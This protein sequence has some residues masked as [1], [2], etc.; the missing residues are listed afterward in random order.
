MPRGDHPQIAAARWDLRL[1]IGALTS[2][3]PLRRIEWIPTE[4]EMLNYKKRGVVKKGC[5][6]INPCFRDVCRVGYVVMTNRLVKIYPMPH[7]YLSNNARLRRA[8]I[9]PK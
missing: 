9:L 7:L 5:P 1:L 6:I 2:R 4:A 3:V 8:R